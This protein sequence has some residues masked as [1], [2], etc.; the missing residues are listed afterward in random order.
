[1]HAPTIVEAFDPID[2]VE[3]GQG[4]RVVAQK[5]D[6]LDLRSLIDQPTIRRLA[7]SMTQA[8]YNQPSPVEM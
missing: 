6:A 5:M 1:M 7:R 8:K 4:T 3:L 2:D